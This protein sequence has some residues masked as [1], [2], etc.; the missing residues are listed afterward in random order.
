MTNSKLVI[1]NLFKNFNFEG[2]F[3]FEMLTVFYVILINVR[4]F[5]LKKKPS[6]V[7]QFLLISIIEVRNL[8]ELFQIRGFRYLKGR[9]V[10][11]YRIRVTTYNYVRNI[12]R[13][14]FFF[15]NS[16]RNFDLKIRYRPK[17]HWHVLVESFQPEAWFGS[18]LK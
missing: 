11:I 5:G 9:S 7:T 8:I 14:H 15:Q 10:H 1:K 17:K 6:Y 12:L 4:L 16:S 18:K 2:S 3:R 13:K